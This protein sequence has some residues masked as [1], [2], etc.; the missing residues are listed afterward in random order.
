MKKIAI[1][2]IMFVLVGFGCRTQE[3]TNDNTVAE[4]SQFGGSL[5]FSEGNVEYAK[6]NDGWFSIEDELN[7]S[8]GD[9]LRTFGDSRAIVQLDDGSILRLNENTQIVF[10]VLTPDH[11]L[12]SNNSGELY[13]RVVKMDRVFE[14][15]VDDVIVKSVGTAYLTT[16]TN[17][18]KSVETY[19]SSVQVVKVGETQELFI[20][21]GEKMYF[22]DQDELLT[23]EVYEM[24]CED[25]DSDDFVMWNKEKDDTQFDKE[26]GF[27]DEKAEENIDKEETTKSVKN[28]VPASTSLSISSLGGGEVK[29]SGYSEKGYKVVWSKNSGPTY[30]TRSG[31]KYYYYSDPNRAY[32]T[33]TAF[34]GSGT[35]Y[36]RVCEYLGGKC[37]EY[38]NQITVTLTDEDKVVEKEAE[39]DNVDS[40]SLSGVGA[41]I[42][43]SVNGYSKKGF[44]VVWS[45]NSGPT[46]PTRSGDK[47]QYHSSPSTSSAS[48]TTFDGSGTYYVR[49]CEYLGGKCGEYS[50]Q[51]T[52]ELE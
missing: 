20:D 40:I 13:S 24:T 41:S 42:S 17:N 25:R 5:I 16:N 1:L 26:M 47:Y 35:Y 7:F 31:D 52:V 45:K 10:D 23:F 19:Q 22:E 48:L 29:W 33:I 43:W 37:G 36:V 38:S 14:V 28:T 46:Y 30:P 32:S 27:F 8:V 39:S 3:L 11:I 21:E 44:K 34:D 9:S 51:I 12:I 4:V 18:E 50:N 15:A 2:A 6:A 49:V